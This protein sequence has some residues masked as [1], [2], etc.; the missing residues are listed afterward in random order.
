MWSTVQ[1]KDHNQAGSDSTFF[2]GRG[3]EKK[4]AVVWPGICVVVE[5]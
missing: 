5:Y 3:V 2:G 1:A 4:E